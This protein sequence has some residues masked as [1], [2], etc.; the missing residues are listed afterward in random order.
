MLIDQKS[1]FDKQDLT[2]NELD[3]GFTTREAISEAKRCLNCPKPLCRTGCPI[4]NEIPG[5]IQSLA[6]GNLGEASAIISR[7]SNLPAVCGRVCPHEKQCEAACILN[8]KDCGIKIGK[9]ERFIADFDTEMDI[10][11]V[12][13]T[14]NAIGKVAV[15][16][17][18]PAGL[19]VAGDLAK[20][21]FAVTVFEGQAE[22]GGVLMYGIPEFRLNKDVVRR[23]IRK[24]EQYGVLFQTGVLIGPDIT[25]DQLFA[26][27]FDAIFMGTGTALPRTLELPGNT[28]PGVIQATYFLSMVQLA[29]NGGLHQKEV[30]VHT[31]D[32]VIVIGA[33]NVAMDAA[34]TALRVG[35]AEVTVVYRRTEKG[36]TALQSEYEEA[37]HEGVKFQWLASPTA[38][39][40]K[41]KVTAL[42]YE[43][44]QID[45]NDR[46]LGTGQMAA[47]PA[48]KV[49]LAIGQRP[50]ARIV[51]STTGIEVNSSGYVITK[52]RPYGMTTRKGVFAGG[53]VV[54]EPATVV[55]AMKEAKKVAAGIAQYVEAKK[56]IEE[57]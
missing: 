12:A 33:G 21:G 43:V 5:F 10:S 17:S 14:K 56:L 39:A 38:F 7:R 15:I 36:I 57:C 50:A 13:K 29:N 18:G 3:E 52:E 35:A 26:D 1:N 9:L 11:A 34:R 54:H 47:L 53:D 30:P 31:G 49:I 2:F 24:I 37:K 6:K 20:A 22:P 45:E 40:G 23:E 28:L 25:V 42:E 48:D 41:G 32:K 4:E 8:K 55:L 27:G 44:Q 16:G 19:T 46:L 51:S